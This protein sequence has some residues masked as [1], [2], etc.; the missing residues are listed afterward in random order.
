MKH[1]K[2]IFAV[3]L[4]ISVFFG[5]VIG[6]YT[7]FNHGT[8][9]FDTQNLSAFDEGENRYYLQQADKKAQVLTNRQPAP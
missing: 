3:I 6:S 2:R 5:A 8:H 4:V 1:L 7:L 9:G